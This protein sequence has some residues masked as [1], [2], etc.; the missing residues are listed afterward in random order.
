MAYPPQTPPPTRAEETLQAGNHPQDHNLLAAAI[1]DVVA[2]LGANPSGAYASL[3]DRLIAVAASAE[4]AQQVED[5]DVDVAAL[6]NDAATPSATFTATHKAPQVN[7][8]TASGT[9]TKPAGAK[10]V[11]ARILSGGGGGSTGSSSSGGAGGGGGG[12][13]MM[14]HLFRPEELAATVPV[15]VGAGGNGAT[16]YGTPGADG[17]ASSFGG[18]TSP[19]GDGGGYAENV[20]HGGNGGGYGGSGGLAGT[21]TRLA[22]G[23]AS[24]DG[25]GGGGGGFYGFGGSIAGPAGGSS[26]F[27]GG[28]GGGGGENG[29]ARGPGGSSAFAGAGGT[30]GAINGV[31]PAGGGAGAPEGTTL[32]GNGQRGEV[33]VV[34]YF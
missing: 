19:G 21:D 26:A 17:G 8:Y 11:V 14:L 13:G 32:G 30:E 24:R 33:T 27:G 20:R 4:G 2:E 15:T 34:T 3:D 28:G 29:G 9:W 23:A 1:A 31:I 25:G 6:L 7:T 12:G 18:I 5:L 10:L 22:V 16:A